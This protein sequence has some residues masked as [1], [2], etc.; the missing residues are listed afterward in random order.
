M[1][2]TRPT[3]Y[4]TS[5]SPLR[6]ME[7]CPADADGHKEGK[8]SRAKTPSRN[9]RGTIKPTARENEIVQAASQKEVE[10]TES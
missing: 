1:S 3:S 4:V 10:K 2:L 6:R 5:T 7:S 8:V 9:S